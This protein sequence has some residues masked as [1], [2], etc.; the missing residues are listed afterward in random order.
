MQTAPAHSTQPHQRICWRSQAPAHSAAAADAH[1]VLLSSSDFSCVILPRLGA[2]D[3]APAAPIL[4]SARTAAPRLASRRPPPPAPARAQPP[5]PAARNIIHAQPAFASICSQR[6]WPPMHTAYFRGSATSDASS[7]RYSVPAMLPHHLRSYFLHAPPPLGSPLAGPHHP[8][9]PREQPPQST[10]RNIIHAQPA[11]ASIRSQRC[12]PPM[13]AAYG[14]GSATSDASSLRDSVPATLPH[15]L[16]WHSLHA[17]PPLGPPL[18]NPHHPLQPRAQPPQPTARNIIHA[19][20]A[21]ASIRSQRCCR[22]C[23]QRTSE[24]QRRQLRHPSETRCQR[25]CPS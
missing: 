13:H 15:R 3:A 24:L 6:C 5:Q 25:R 18:A 14:K 23:T 8:L 11:F 20:P 7:F 1:S 2:S 12:W 19:Q 4:L 16:R 22:R 10:A 9:Q 17:P 21:F